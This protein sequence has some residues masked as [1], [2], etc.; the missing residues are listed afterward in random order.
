MDFHEQVSPYFHDLLSLMD[1]WQTMIVKNTWVSIENH[2][3][4]QDVL[5]IFNR[6]LAQMPDEKPAEIMNA[7]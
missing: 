2:V 4:F 5:P 3:T 6:F 1:E 7:V